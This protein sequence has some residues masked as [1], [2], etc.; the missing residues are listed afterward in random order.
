M[1]SYSYKSYPENDDDKNI[2]G[3]ETCAWEYGNPACEYFLASFSPAATL[4]LDKMWNTDDRAYNREYRIAMTKLILGIQTPYN[5]D[6]FEVF[7][8]IMPPRT[9]EN[10]T[11]VTLENEL[12]DKETLEKH[13]DLLKRIT[14]TYS[15]NYLNNVCEIITKELD[16]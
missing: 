14:K 6:M 16:I 7:G 2:I 9:S 11:Y 1:A 15:A 3:A 12:I 8:S 4:M 13:I 10:A 5:Y